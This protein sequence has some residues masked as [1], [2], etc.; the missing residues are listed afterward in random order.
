MLGFTVL[1]LAPFLIDLLLLAAITTAKDRDRLYVVAAI[2]FVVNVFGSL[3]LGYFVF[4][5][6]KSDWLEL[7]SVVLFV[8]LMR[9]IDLFGFKGLRLFRDAWERLPFGRIKISVG[10]GSP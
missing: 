4:E 10:G 1:L 8:I 9:A 5:K 6:A 2:Y 3:V 7:I